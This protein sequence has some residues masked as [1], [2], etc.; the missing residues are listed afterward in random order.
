MNPPIHPIVT[1]A[2]D[3]VEKFTRERKI[4][5]EVTLPE[6]MPGEFGTDKAG[7]FVSLKINGELRGC[8]GTFMPVTQ[9]IVEETIRNA[10]AAASEDPRFPPVDVASLGLLITRWTS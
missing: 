10:V 8:I 4:P 6:D 7:V 2:K 9:S 1:L 5:K 3:T